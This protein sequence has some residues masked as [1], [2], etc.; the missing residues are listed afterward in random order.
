MANLKL[1][2]YR[3][4]VTGEWEVGIPYLAKGSDGQLVK[5]AELEAKHPQGA[6]S[7]ALA[8]QWYE[9]GEKAAETDI[10]SG[11]LA[12]PFT[13]L[14]GNPTDV[15]ISPNEQLVAACVSSQVM[16]WELATGKMLSRTS[17]PNYASQLAFAPDSRRILCAGMMHEV[18]VINVEDGKLIQQLTGQA[19]SGI[20]TAKAI[21]YLP[22][23]RG[24]VSAGYDG[25]I[26]VWRLPD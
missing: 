5:L 25:I 7:L 23:P 26:R 10:A 1:G 15:V 22:D 17:M 6:D 21:S 19:R 4:F 8:N 3:C 16:I 12:A 14:G 18:S 2:R 13:G 24:A 20:S 9:W 11:Q